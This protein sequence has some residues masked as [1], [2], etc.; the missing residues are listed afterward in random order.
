MSAFDLDFDSIATIAQPKPTAGQDRFIADLRA[1]WQD[2]EDE[3]ARLLGR[4]PRRPAW[5]DPASREEASAMI[6]KGKNARDAHRALLR[7]ARAAARAA[8]VPARAE[9]TEGMWIIG[10]IGSDDAR[11][12]KVQLAVHGSGRLY[13][14]ELIA[15]SFEFAPGAMRELA[16][17]GR[18]MTLAEAKQYGALYG[19]C[20]VCGRTLT[21]EASIAAGIGPVCA[22]RF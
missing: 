10:K 7:E 11:I 20:C 1:A 12:Y 17:S 14:K 22:Q 16:T 8:S 5:V 2:A 3:L 13:A 9:V 4:E 15:G 21:N 19:T 6:D 18:K